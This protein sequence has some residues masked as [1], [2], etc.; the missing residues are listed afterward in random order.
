[1]SITRALN[2]HLMKFLTKTIYKHSVN[3]ELKT[4]EGQ[5]LE[6]L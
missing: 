3:I 4:R 1:M 2:K 5:I 6:L